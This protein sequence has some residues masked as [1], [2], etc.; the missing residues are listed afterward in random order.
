M[1]PVAD[2]HERRPMPDLVKDPRYGRFAL[3][4]EMA[5]AGDVVRRLSL[6]R[7]R[8]LSEHVK[9][10]VLLSG[11]GSSRIFPAKKTISDAQRLLYQE[12]LFT[13]GATEALEYD[14][15]GASVFLASNSGKTKEGVRLMR[16]LRGVPGVTV[17]GIAGVE[18]TPIL[19]EADAGYALGC[20][21]ERAVAATKSVIEQ[22]LVYDLLFRLR[23]RKPLPDLDEL[24]GAIEETF[25]SEVPAEVIDAA[26]AADTLYWSGRNNGV[27]EELRLK[28]NEIARKKSDFLEGTYA[29]HGVEEVLGPRDVVVCVE[30][31]SDEEPKFAEALGR[32][33]GVPIVAIATRSTFFPTFRIPS[34]GDFTPYLELVAGWRLLVEVGV[35]AGIDLDKTRRARKV[36]NELVEPKSGH[37][38]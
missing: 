11:E 13:V 29:V 31:F 18:G 7:I 10:R 5:E 25:A 34:L 4:R 23:N 30:P 20:G 28:T 24:A 26:A 33:A 1:L 3:V 17:I 38:K 27:G 6:D 15:R 36:G 32:G 16:A 8:N 14:L 12:Q 22:A 35:A 37:E 9:D 2:A 21:P 19:E